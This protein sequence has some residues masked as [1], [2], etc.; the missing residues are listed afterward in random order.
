VAA[1]NLLAHLLVAT[2]LISVFLGG[3]LACLLAAKSSLFR[4]GIWLS[5]GS[6][7]MSAGYVRL[8]KLAY[9]LIGLGMLLMLLLLSA[10]RT[11][12]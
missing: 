2:F 5:F 7:R 12:A 3:G 9:V 1:L 11:I 10:L 8:Y 4:Q 6:G